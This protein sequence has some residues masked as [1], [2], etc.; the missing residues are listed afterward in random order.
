M[1]MSIV[2]K[3]APLTVEGE[4][5]EEHG[6]EIDAVLAGGVNITELMDA[7]QLLTAIED[8]VERQIKDDADEARISRQ[9]NQSKGSGYEHH[10]RRFR[11]PHQGS[12]GH[13]AEFLQSVSAARHCIRA[14]PPREAAT[15][16]GMAGHPE[17]LCACTP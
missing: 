4:Y 13:Q 15:R 9:S 11:G 8:A 16:A 6:F 7:G 12:A 1:R 2:F 5:S 17:G 14:H 3:G 10:Q